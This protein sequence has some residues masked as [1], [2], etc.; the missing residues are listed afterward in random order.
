MIQRGKQRHEEGYGRGEAEIDASDDVL[1]DEEAL[2]ERILAVFRAPD[3]QPPTLPSTATQLMTLS[4]NP[5]VSFDDVVALLERDQMLAARVLKLARSPIYGGAA[6]ID[7]LRDALMR[8]GLRTLRDLVLEAAMN[9]RVFRSEAYTAPM[10]RLREHSQAVAVT[11]RVVSK[12]TPVEGEY[13]FLCGLLHDVGVAGILVSLADVPKGKAAPDLSILWP[14]IHAAHAEAGTMMAKIWD[15][16]AEIPMVLDA[17]HR[18]EID[19]YPHPLGATICIADRIAFELGYGFV[20]LP[21]EDEDGGP[22]VEK[23]DLAGLTTHPSTDASGPVALERAREALGLTD[24]TIELI[25][26]EAS[27]Q[28]SELA[29]G[30][31]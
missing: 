11:S 5:E 28:L 29:G 1:I 3:Y 20:P 18:V 27:G 8:L 17:H 7:S 25:R 21:D 13:A 26:D 10:E 12:Y 15:L 6:R 22:A 19:G 16:P 24:A 9:L 14:A 30:G 2:R 4:Q 23:D 31:A